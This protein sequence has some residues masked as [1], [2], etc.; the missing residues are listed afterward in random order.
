[1]TPERWAQIEDIFHRAADC[2]V[3]QRTIV[4]NVF[5][6]GDEDLR[7]EVEILLGSDGMASVY[8]QT[9]IRAHLEEIAFPLTGQTI[10]HYRIEEGLDQGGMGQIYRAED[11]RL[12]RAVA[13]KF[14]PQDLTG[15]ASSLSRFEREA[16]TASALEHASIC[17]VYEY[18]SHDGIPF[19]VMPLLRGKTLRELIDDAKRNH[20][21]IRSEDLLNWAVQ[22]ADGLDFVL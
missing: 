8:L 14:L 4:L 7:R 6:Q 22:I 19:I 17:P 5:C 16:R 18:G 21:Q 11:I 15:N 20:S 2:D 9:S 13:L 1:V 3:E 12:G 10:D